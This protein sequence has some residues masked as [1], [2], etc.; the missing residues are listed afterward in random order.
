V[1]AVGPRPGRLTEFATVVPAPPGG[2]A[3]AL[4]R[5]A[6]G[7]GE[8]G[9]LLAA[10]R[11][12]GERSG[13][14]GAAERP[15]VVVLAGWRAATSGALRAAE[16]L[17]DGLGGAFAWVPRRAGDRGALDAGARPDLLPGG[18]RVAHAA[19]AELG[20]A[21]GAELPAE[22][23]LDGPAMVRAAAEGR[24]GVL[25]LAGV[26]LIRDYGPRELAERALDRAF[27]IAVDHV[28]ND[29][30][31]R[32][33]VLLPGVVHAETEG[34]WTDWEGRVQGQGAAVPIGGAAQAIWELAD[35]L[36]VRLQV[37]LGLATLD[38]VTAET[39]RFRAR[40]AAAVL[41]RPQGPAPAEPAEPAAAQRLAGPADGLALVTYP[42]LLDAASMLARA[43]DLNRGTLP[44]FVELHPDDA[45]RLGV[46]DG[47]P[48]EVD[49]GGDRVLELPARLSHA[50]AAGCVFIPANQPDL[51]LGELLGTAPP[52][53]VA[54]RATREVAA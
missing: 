14:M 54:V 5:L 6:R 29:T 52:L 10:A 16:R 15:P 2:E 18:R 7:E 42:L 49:L 37:D 12:Q 30:T 44:A 32:A 33:D 31:R 28:L 46:R 17:A 50:L 21:W 9:E 13:A 53:R 48:V 35:Q 39:E 51:A 43:D 3:A 22:P 11:S 25:V 47:A 41:A 34:T 24:L 45:E 38:R 20:E 26:D 8:A 19:L 27:V 4:E 40:P 23:G 36:A 1:I